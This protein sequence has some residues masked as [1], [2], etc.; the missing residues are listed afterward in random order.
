MILLGGYMEYIKE[1][2][3]VL[4]MD[5]GNIIGEVTFPEQDGLLNINHTYV[6]PS[7]RGMHIADSL[8]QHAYEVIL[9]QKRTCIA[10][11]SYA[12]KWFQDHPEKQ[13]IIK[14]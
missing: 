9:N 11:C 5:H 2:N 7:F 14:K 8:L 13:H 10:T 3:R 6:D 12:K 1:K 4:A